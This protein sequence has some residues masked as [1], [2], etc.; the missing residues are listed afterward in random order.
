MENTRMTAE[1]LKQLKTSQNR[2][3]LFQTQ[4]SKVRLFD[5]SFG[6]YAQNE[7]AANLNQLAAS[8]S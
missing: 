3:N 5:A 4:S 1:K 2:V 8:H 7:L 6:L